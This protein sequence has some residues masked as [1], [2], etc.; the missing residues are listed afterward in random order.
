MFV[1]TADQVSSRTGAD[2]ADSALALIERGR[3]ARL[4][5]PPDR[6]AGDEVQALTADPGA[7]LAIALEL[8]RTGS[9]SV[10]MGVGAVRMPLA[11]YTRAA[12]GPAFFAARDAV[13]RAKKRPTRFALHVA[14]DPGSA[15][16]PA[17]ALIDLV[18]ALRARRSAAGWEVYDL[19]ASGGSQ[20][21]AAAELGISAAAVGARVRAAGVREELA[22]VPVLATL[23]AGLDSDG[24]GA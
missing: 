7:A 16:S 22:A 21:A 14:G 19:L 20:R 12:S 2:L 15:P 13:A 3:R 10:G 24:E 8:T 17:E 1:I 11:G 18:L 5:L 4:A 6:T 9:W 23:V